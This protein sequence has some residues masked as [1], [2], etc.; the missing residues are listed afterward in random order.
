LAENTC[1]EPSRFKIGPAV[2]PGRGAK[3]T[4]TKNKGKTKSRDKLGVR[5]V[6]PY[7][8]ASGHREIYL[9]MATNAPWSFFWGGGVNKKL[10]IK[11]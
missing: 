7:L 1:Y 2:W 4:Q 3:N 9:T 6:Y 11:L 8:Q 5:G 10:N